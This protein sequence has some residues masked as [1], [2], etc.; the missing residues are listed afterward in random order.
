M[1]RI[2]ASASKV[3]GP[4]VYTEEIG[5]RKWDDDVDKVREKVAGIIRK[6]Y[7]DARITL[8]RFV[9]Y[10][11]P[12]IGI[13]VVLI[14]PKTEK[15]IDRVIV[16]AATYQIVPR[17]MLEQGRLGMGMWS[18]YGSIPQKDRP[19]RIS[20]WE[21][22]DRLDDLLKESAKRANIN[23]KAKLS[24]Q[25]LQTLEKTLMGTS[26]KNIG[27]GNPMPLI[28]LLTLGSKIISIPLHG[29]EH[30]CWCAPATG[31]MILRHHHYY[32]EQSDIA[33]AME[34][35]PQPEDVAQWG[36]GLFFPPC[37][38]ST[39]PYQNGM[40]SL[41]HNYLRAIDDS[42]PT[43]QKVKEEIDQDRP[44][45]CP[46]PGHARACSGYNLFEFRIVPGIV[47]G[48]ATI[49]FQ[50][51]QSLWIKNP[52]PVNQNNT[53]CNPQGGDEGWEDW[54]VSSYSS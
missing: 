39:Q 20:R 45:Y 36:E 14:D 24:D 33:V 5:P 18:M 27:T 54:D 10:S 37:G 31:Q 30:E 41:S 15:E 3:L 21:D 34:T 49:S 11:Y 19:D 6:Q 22:D 7:K 35:I 53:F 26:K 25:E 48:D 28:S 46:V 12:K 32:Y 38:T 40:E 50:S 44:F 23:V 4:S 2:K 13:L 9:C 17:I 1:G 29:Q 47:T 52:L 8:T 51:V 43:W 42:S 16:D